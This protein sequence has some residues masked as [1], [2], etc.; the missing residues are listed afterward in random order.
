MYINSKWAR[1]WGQAYITFGKFN[2]LPMTL[3]DAVTDGWVM[4]NTGS[5]GTDDCN[6]WAWFLAQRTT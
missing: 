5:T 2:Q 4:N 6:N 1:S 3:A